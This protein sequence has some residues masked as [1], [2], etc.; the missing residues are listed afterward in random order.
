MPSA[1]VDLSL[2]STV[3]GGKRPR[4]PTSD[5]PP[6]SSPATTSRT[7]FLAI[8]WLWDQPAQRLAPSCPPTRSSKIHQDYSSEMEAIVYCLV[9]L[10]LL[11]SYT[12]FFLGFY[13]DHEDVALRVGGPSSES[14]PGEVPAF[15]MSLEDGKPAQWLYL[16]PGPAEAVSRWEV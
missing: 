16:L 7:I 1:P 8:P 5:H 13:S 2:V 14:W 3:F 11:T 4:T 6:T 15:L 9:N 12:H 10:H